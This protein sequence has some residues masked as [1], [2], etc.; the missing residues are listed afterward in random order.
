ME[1]STPQ[2]QSRGSSFEYNL[3]NLQYVLG[4][5]LNIKEYQNFKEFLDLISMDQEE[6]EIGQ[7]LRESI[8]NHFG[9]NHPYWFQIKQK[10][11]LKKMKNRY[12]E[13]IK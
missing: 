8:I 10:L 2:F 9:E 11:F 1:V 6:S 13:T 4:N 12:Y 3:E 7:N 5:P